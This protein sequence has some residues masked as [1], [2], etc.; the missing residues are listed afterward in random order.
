MPD[1]TCSLE[2]CDKPVKARGWCTGHYQQWRNHGDPAHTP[3]AGSGTCLGCGGPIQDK[4]KY[5]YCRV[6]PECAREYSVRWR[7]ANKDRQDELS[8]RWREANPD[9]VRA[10]WRRSMENNRETRRVSAARWRE[11]HPDEF[12]EACKR[13]RQA[14]LERRRQTKKRRLARTDRPCRQRECSDFAA[15]GREYCRKHDSQASARRHARRVRA[16]ERRLYEQQDG[17]CPDADH[18]GCG[19]ELIQP[20]GHH[21]DH[22]I[23]LARNGPDEEWNLQLMHRTCNLRK[24][25]KLVPAA[26]KL[27]TIRGVYRKAG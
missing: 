10:S 7:A 13:W 14:N 26:L 11:A 4:N 22:L 20:N 21:L 23:P 19:E 2:S 9:K 17:K 12:R 25:I 3:F 15:T 18:G 8:T 24:G 6:N 16:L 5:G 1:G 27:A